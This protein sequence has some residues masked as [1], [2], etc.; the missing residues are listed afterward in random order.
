MCNVVEAYVDEE[1]ANEAATYVLESGAEGAVPVRER[2]DRSGMSRRELARRLR[3]SVPQLYRLLDPTNTKKSIGRLVALLH[4]L[5][6]DVRL[7]V[8]ERRAA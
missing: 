5:E 4:L 1:L 2:V 6:C 3:T 7:G 8:S